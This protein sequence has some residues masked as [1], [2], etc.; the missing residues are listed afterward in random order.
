MTTSESRDREKANSKLSAAFNYSY[1][2][3][4]IL[5]LLTIGATIA[6][7]EI[8]NNL[9]TES[10]R[11]WTP[12]VFLIGFCVSLL[13]FGATYRE[14]QARAVLQQKTADLL[15]SQKKNAELLAAEQASRVR[16]E[17]ANLAKD[18]FLAVVSHE[19]RTPLNAIAGWNRILRTH[20]ISEETKRT[21][22]EK[23][24]KNL[25][26]QTSIV[27]E[28]LDFSDVMSSSMN[29]ERSILPMRGI[30]EE[31]MA[32]ASVAAFQK[33]VTLAGD[34]ALDEECVLGDRHKLKLAI[35][36]VLTN[37]VKFTPPGG[38][39]AAKAF[40]DDGV[41]KLVVEDNGIGIEPDMITHIFDEYRQSEH[42]TT[43]HYGG[44]GLGLTIAGHIVKLHKGTID[45]ESMGI[46]QGSTF[47]ITIPRTDATIVH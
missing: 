17:K 16:A 40:C 22:V 23:I 4:V 12:V 37:A 36:N 11:L 2:V 20:G 38:N 32:T 24:D 14:I 41:V 3:L 9:D 31:A 15:E 29:M 19:L 1:V 47:T 18:E 5:L 34:D 21:A 39:I 45:V 30:L 25:R 44:L 28:L 33:G 27:E 13:I 8:S 7:F 35:T 10:G 6:F 42:A 46:G 26:L 43:R